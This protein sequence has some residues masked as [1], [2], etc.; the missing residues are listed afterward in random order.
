LHKILLLPIGHTRF[1]HD[2][3]LLLFLAFKSPYLH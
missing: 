2:L 3:L 1:C